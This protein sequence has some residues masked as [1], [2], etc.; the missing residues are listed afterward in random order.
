MTTRTDAPL[1]KK[2]TD[3]TFGISNKWWQGW[4]FAFGAISNPENGPQRTGG[5]GRIE[6]GVAVNGERA[7][8]FSTFWRCVRLITETIGSLPLT[9]A[10]VVDGERV[11]LE[12]DHDVVT[13]LKH[14]PNQM[15]NALEFREAI[16]ACVTVNGN[17]YSQ[18]LRA[19]DR[20]VGLLPLDP[21]RMTP[22]RLNG[23]ITYHYTHDKGVHIYAARNIMHVKGFSFDGVV[24]LST[25]S[26]ARQS[27]GIAI[28]A[29]N[30]AA[31]TFARGGRP[32]G[33]LTYDKFLN[34]EQRAL[35]KENYELMVGGDNSGS[36]LFLEGGMAFE[37]N[38]I[39]PDDMQMLQ[40]RTFSVS[41]IGRFFGVPSHMLND[42]EKSTTFG[43]GIEE[44]N[45]AFLAYTIRPYLTRHES[46]YRDTLLAPSERD[47]II[48][49]HNVEGLLRSNSKARAEFYGAM[50]DHGLYSRNDVR[51]KENLPLIPGGDTFTV[52]S[53]L[54]P[55][56][57]LGKIPSAADP[58][59]LPAI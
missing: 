26:Y 2:E 39:P 53:T 1:R 48:V 56:D 55:L 42:S 43:T 30:Y 12:A 27:L 40:S 44:I 17:A 29:D 18:I 6:S 41:D 35:I 9:F 34:T 7:M 4:G 38:S 8:Q 11:E 22:T 24:G 3:T 19:G 49:E 32:T 21:A 31:H 59:E 10:R 5:G 45:L 14:R 37:P 46:V 51:R 25:L 23:E 50:V 36:A 54:V 33:I 28:A 57:K 13:L 47:V 20:I 58:K 16:A 15:M 52:M